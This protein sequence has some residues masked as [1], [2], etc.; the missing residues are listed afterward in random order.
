MRVGDGAWAQVVM[1]SWDPASEGLVGLEEE[2]VRGVCVCVVGGGGEG[3]RGGG[4]VWGGGGGGGRGSKGA[5]G[6]E[7]FLVSHYGLARGVADEPT[8]FQSPPPREQEVRSWASEHN[9][10]LLVLLALTLTTG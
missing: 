7:T 10:L 3:G 4:G 2:E 9:A 5:G 1:R 8:T 6:G